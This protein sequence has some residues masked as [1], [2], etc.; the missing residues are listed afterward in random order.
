MNALVKRS[1]FMKVKDLRL[2]KQL[3]RM[4]RLRVAEGI[5]NCSFKYY[6]FSVRRES[7]LYAPFS[8]IFPPKANDVNS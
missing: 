4:Y 2:G 6:S 7:K 5:W 3:L 8:L 1:F